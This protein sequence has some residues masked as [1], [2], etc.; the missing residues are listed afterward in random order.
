MAYLG[1]L[2][3]SID[4]Q[5]NS[6]LLQKPPEKWDIPCTRAQ[7]GWEIMVRHVGDI[8]PISPAVGRF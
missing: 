6:L 7:A 2:W 3:G 4:P 1:A 5:F 8:Q